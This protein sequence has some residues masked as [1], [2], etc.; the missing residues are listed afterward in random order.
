MLINAKFG[1]VEHIIVN[2]GSTD[3]TDTICRG[4]AKCNAHIK[5]ISF[6]ANRGTNAARNAAIGSATGDFCIIL[7][8]DDY[9]VDNAISMINKIVTSHPTYKHFMFAP[10]DIN[11]GKSI[12][13]GLEEKE[14]TYVD[15]LSGRIKTG[16]IHCIS[17]DI[18]KRYPFDEGVRIYEGVFFLSFYK[19]AQKMWFT[20]E[21]VTIRERGRDDSVTLNL[22]RT[23][24]VVIE[25]GIKANEMMLSLFGSDMNQYGC[26][27][28]LSSVYTFLYDNY[29]LLGQY[30]QMTILKEMYKENYANC[31]CASR[32]LKVLTALTYLR[33]GWLYRFMLQ[34]Y[35]IVRYRVLRKKTA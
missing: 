5:Y 6:A 10:N 15:F 18:M 16:F 11:Y 23:K 14:L 3:L 20:N 31:I 35:L 25:R 4:Y 34:L 33:L 30:K 13:A 22:V 27:K 17:S 26:T 2:D 9:F 32:K 19:E 12:L 21:V 8:S 24:R 7:D 28:M 1:G 29:L